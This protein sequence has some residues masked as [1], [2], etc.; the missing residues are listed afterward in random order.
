MT[1]HVAGKQHSNRR[2]AE[3]TAR[4]ERFLHHAQRLFR[5]QGYRR[6]SLADIIAASGGSRETLAK[7][8]RN[9]AGL[10]AAVMNQGALEFLAHSHLSTLKG[11]PDQVLRAYA[12]MALRFFMQPAAMTTYRDVVSECVHAPD[13]AAA[14]HSNAHGRVVK[15]LAAQLRVWRQQGLVQTPDPEEDADCFT[16]MLRGGLHEDVLLGLRAAPMAS[17]IRRKCDGVV[18]LFLKGI[19]PR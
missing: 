14:F 19:S 11:T 4:R 6:T 3:A 13:M 12:E 17:E 2:Q 18:R 16:H 5:R 9:K 10:Y 7:Y 8:F 15:A 1:K